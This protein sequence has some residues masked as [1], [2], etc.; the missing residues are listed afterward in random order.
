MNNCYAFANKKITELPLKEKKTKIRNRYFN[1]IVLNNNGSTIINKR[2]SKDIW[3]NLYD[4]PLIETDQQSEETK[5]LAS[6]EWKKLI[7]KNKYSI[8]AVSTSYKHILSHQHI[9]AKFW[10]IECLTE[11]KKIKPLTA[12]VIKQKDIHKYAVP[13]LIENYLEKRKI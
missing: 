7:G 13:R 6:D 4:F 3:T 9:Y 5:I 1:Y 11:L 10:E 2:L 12:L 8:K